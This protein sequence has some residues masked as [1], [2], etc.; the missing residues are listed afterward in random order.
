MLDV[1]ALLT[2][3]D[4]IAWA[5]DRAKR[6]GVTPE[7]LAAKVGLTRPGMLHWTK[8]STDVNAVGVGRL[9]AFSQATNVNLDW[10]L[11]GRGHPV[12]TYN[13]SDEITALSKTLAVLAAEE[14]A[15]Y[16]VIARMIR[17]A[18]HDPASHN[19]GTP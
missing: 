17:A 18:P 7:A 2:A 15:E 4:R 1:N 11:T 10:L 16:R 14:P 9:I 12:D 3:Q 5:I 13:L 19:G 6:R 8:E